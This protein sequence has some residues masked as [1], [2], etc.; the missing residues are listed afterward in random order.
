MRARFRDARALH[1]MAKAGQKTGDRLLQHGLGLLSQE[2]LAGVTLGRLAQQAGLSK[3]GV[4]A[5]FKSKSE[6]Q[7]AL[8]DYTQQFVAPRVVEP[9]LREPA[10][11]P[12]LQALVGHWFGWA[13]RAGLPGGCPIAS[14]MF[15]LD[16]VESPVRDKVQRMEA[17]W[18]GL[19]AQIVSEAVAAGELSADLDVEQFV[20][21]LCGIYLA[22]HVAT[23]FVRDPAADRRAQI[24]VNALLY[25]A[26]PSQPQ[27]RS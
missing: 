1:K 26:E 22:H 7:L 16:D 20:W 18:R 10:G 25:R 21:E 19:L 27:E 5:H 8:L 23:R 2:G 12:R 11:V 15:E 14:A 24:A 6:V 13:E 17:E 3:S 9:A 4:F